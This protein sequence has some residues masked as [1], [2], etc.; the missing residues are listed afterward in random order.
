M[1]RRCFPRLLAIV[2]A[3]GLVAGCG[4]NGES[5]RGGTL[6]VALLDDLRTLDP[7][8]TNQIISLQV[9]YQMFETLVK[10]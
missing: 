7:G 2:V 1:R 4:T 10:L 6:V 8:T 5:G 3:A 9:T